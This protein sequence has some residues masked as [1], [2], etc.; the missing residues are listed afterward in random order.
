MVLGHA[1][2][3]LGRL[4]HAAAAYE[5]ALRVAPAL[6]A[7]KELRDHL[8]EVLAGKDLLASLL[9]LDLLAT[10]TPPQHDAIITYASTGKVFDVRHRAVM[11]A[12]RDGVGDKVDRVQSW[13][14]DLQQTSS[15]DERKATIELLARTSDR[16]VLGVLKRVR[17]VKCI[18]REA[19]DAIA[20]IEGTA[21]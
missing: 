15:C 21:R 10:L 8:L 20:R 9:A 7:D 3:A 18:E 12:E 13:T 4:Q 14:L 5:R 16:R 2:L 17:S 1:Q 19:T 11:I 6:G